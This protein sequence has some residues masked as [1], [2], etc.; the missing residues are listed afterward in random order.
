M[1]KAVR[2]IL[3]YSLKESLKLVIIFAV[4]YAFLYTSW[5]HYNLQ[6]VPESNTVKNEL[7]RFVIKTSAAHKW[8]K[9][10]APLSE[11][12]YTPPIMMRET[13]RNLGY[14]VL[15][16]ID[17]SI[18]NGIVKI[19][20]HEMVKQWVID[21]TTKKLVRQYFGTDNP[22][23]LTSLIM[24]HKTL[25][26]WGNNLSIYHRDSL[27]EKIRENIR[28]DANVIL[29]DIDTFNG[30][31]RIRQKVANIYTEGKFREK[32][33]GEIGLI[34]SKRRYFKSFAMTILVTFIF[35]FLSLLIILLLSM[36]FINVKYLKKS[37]NYPLLDIF[38]FLFSLP[39]LIWI[40]GVYKFGFEGAIVAFL[41][42]TFGSGI[43]YEIFNQ[44]EI[45]GK[46]EI[47]KPYFQILLTSERL[48]GF[49]G[50]LLNYTV[51]RNN[52]E[53]AVKRGV[54]LFDTLFLILLVIH[55]NNRYFL[56]RFFPRAENA[57]KYVYFTVLI[58][59]YL[60]LLFIFR[61]TGKIIDTMVKYYG[62]RV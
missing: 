32:V 41:L 61:V 1:K 21:S 57:D 38:I 54:Y 6:R 27:A 13:L 44:S 20:Y 31:S 40:L 8:K 48:R 7:E 29:A 51:L 36:V 42:L 34:K 17:S 24:N 49:T 25:E 56:T 33:E 11:S 14:P 53:L 28:L 18:W 59:G 46:L 30:I 37:S 15:S 12:P 60:I 26:R 58:I 35:M 43:A 5:K 62:G 55:V 39:S 2:A 23:T 9:F 47:T 3:R 4:S 22:D 52:I 45:I 50:K 19:F 10:L 16:N